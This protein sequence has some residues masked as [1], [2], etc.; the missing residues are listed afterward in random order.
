MAEMM[1][2]YHGKTLQKDGIDTD[3]GMQESMIKLTL[4]NISAAPSEGEKIQFT[5][6][7]K[8]EEV[9]KPL[10]MSKNDSAPGINGATNKLYKVL[11]DRHIEDERKGIP[12][13]DIVGVLTDVFNDIESYGVDEST[14]FTEGWMC[15]IYKKNDRNLMSN[16]RPITL[17][18][19]EYKLFTKA[20]SIKLVKS[21]PELIHIDQAGFIPGR[22]IS[23]QTKLI[24][25]IIDHADL[26][27]QN[28]MI[29]ALDQ[30]KAYDKI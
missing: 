9:L 10:N 23:N 5:L 18:N 19:S 30:E 21:A 8:R 22:Q 20:L 15:P 25:M 16:Y 3:T 13:F 29:V 2:D 26:A 27:L 11:N 7:T 24:R 6:R 12:S 14:N 17:L 4:N 28:G 1:R